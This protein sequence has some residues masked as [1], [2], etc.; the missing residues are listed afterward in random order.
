MKSVSSVAVAFSVLFAAG[1]GAEV[2]DPAGSLAVLSAAQ[3]DSGSKGYLGLQSGHTV[4]ASWS[5]V[6]S[7][8]RS[9]EYWVTLPAYDGSAPRT[10]TGANQTCNQ[11][12]RMVCG[13][14]WT[15][16]TY[17]QS[18]Y[19]QTELNCAFPPG[20]CRASSRAVPLLAAGSHRTSD[21]AGAPFAWTYV[22]GQCEYW[23]MQHT[24]SSG[25]SSQ[26]PLSP[27]YTSLSDFATQVCAMSPVPTTWYTAYYVPLTTF[28]SAS[29]C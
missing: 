6:I 29:A 20:P 21:A 11:F 28:C 23:A 17:Y 14:G 4:L 15:G 9:V 16:A 12:R 2:A 25:E 5:G 18:V 3:L 1:C 7:S 10:L 22:A 19:S 27:G 26:A 13:A 8:G 24:I